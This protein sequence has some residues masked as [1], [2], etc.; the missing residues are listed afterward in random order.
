MEKKN[1]HEAELMINN[2]LFARVKIKTRSEIRRVDS[3]KKKNFQNC[4]NL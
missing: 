4:T 3:K 2:K 1:D